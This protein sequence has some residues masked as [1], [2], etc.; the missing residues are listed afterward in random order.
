MNLQTP[1]KLSDLLSKYPEQKLQSNWGDPVFRRAVWA[2]FFENLH[3]NKV[4]Y[5][6]RFICLARIENLRIDE[7]GVGG[8]VVPLQYFYS[9]P[10]W[11]L[12]TTAWGFGGGWKTMNQGDGCLGQCYA[13][14]TIWPE[15][16]RVRAVETLLGRGD[17]EGALELLYGPQR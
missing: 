14:W 10:G 2:P 17:S 4:V 15:P 9:Y 1:M 16:A 6:E 8:V 11:N 5:R 13:G 12:P 7:L 3:E